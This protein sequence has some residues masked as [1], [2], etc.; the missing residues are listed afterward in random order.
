MTRRPPHRVHTIDSRISEHF[1]NVKDG[2]DDH[3]HHHHH[4]NAKLPS[5]PMAG[6]ADDND[7]YHP[8][9][10]ELWAQEE[11]KSGHRIKRGL[12]L[13]HGQHKE[14]LADHHYHNPS[15]HP[16]PHH[17]VDHPDHT[18]HDHHH[19]QQHQHHDEHGKNPLLRYRSLPHLHVHGEV[20]SDGRDSARSH[21]QHQQ[22]HNNHH[23]HNSVLAPVSLFPKRPDT[24]VPH[25][26][27]RERSH[28]HS[29]ASHLHR[30]D[31]K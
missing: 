13:F 3:H 5:I 21:Q 26:D 18:H 23:H 2:H 7:Y 15:L 24:L 28:H 4:H 22:H 11:I 14:N 10:L 20:S 12:G 16:H 25:E 27:E 8:S 9:D 31:E 30:H 19:H 29:A 17:N 6:S 1:N